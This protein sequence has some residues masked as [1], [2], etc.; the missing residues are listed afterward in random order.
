MG[1]EGRWPSLTGPGGVGRGSVPDGSQ[2]PSPPQCQEGEGATSCPSPKS[3]F[4]LKTGAGEEL[5]SWA[6]GGLWG[7]SQGRGQ[8][9]PGVPCRSCSAL[10]T[11]STSSGAS[12]P[13]IP[14]RPPPL[15]R[16]AFC[17]FKPNQRANKFLRKVWKFLGS[18]TLLWAAGGRRRDGG[19]SH[20]GRC[21]RPPV[22]GRVV[23][24]PFPQSHSTS[25]L[26]CPRMDSCACAKRRGEPGPSPSPQ[27]PTVP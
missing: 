3:H 19:R 26:P 21:G 18:S 14:R 16:S 12:L 2:P 5:G 24:A 9:V 13:V 22:G 4:P 11:G 15:P 10:G 7:L 20:G 6:A 25:R 8:G 23:G 17:F 1:T 27:P